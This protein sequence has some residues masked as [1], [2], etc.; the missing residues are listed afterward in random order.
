MQDVPSVKSRLFEIL[1]YS[2]LSN[3]ADISAELILSILSVRGSWEEVSLHF[4]EVNDKFEFFQL[5]EGKIVPSAA[6]EE[7]WQKYHTSLVILMVCALA[8]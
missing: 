8:G 3:E 6:L 7:F 4:S 1:E 5:F 2:L